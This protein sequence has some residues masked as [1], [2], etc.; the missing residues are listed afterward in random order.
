MGLVTQ[1]LR[2]LIGAA[3]PG[4]K[5]PSVR[6]LMS[7]YR[8]SPATVE[9]AFAQLAGE[10]L[11]DPKPGQGTFVRPPPVAVAEAEFGDADLSWQAVALGQGR[12][13]TDIMS[14]LLALPSPGTIA[15][16]MGYLPPDLQATG[17]LK[18][19]LRQAAGRPDLWDRLPLEGLEALR[20]WFAREVG[21][22]HVF[23]PHEVLVCPGGQAAIASTFRALVPPGRPLLVEAPTYVGAI[24]AARAAGVQL[25]PVPSDGNGVRPDLLADAFR[26]TGAK[27]FYGQPT[28]ANPSGVVLSP[29]RRVAVLDIARTARAFVIE[30]DWA[31]DLALGGPPPA[32]LATQ[33][34][35]G[36]VVYI[37]SL[38]K[39][40]APGLRV[41]AVM[42]R[43]A[44]L[45]RLRSSR[46]CD[47]FFVCGPLQA[48]AL[49]V[50][51]APGWKR[52]LQAARTSLRER[53]DALVAAL[54]TELG[55]RLAFHVPDGGMHLWVRLPDQV[56]DAAL[57]ADLA[58]RSVIV[59]PGWIWFPADPAGSYL[60]LTF[61]ASPATLRDGVKQ[62]RSALRPWL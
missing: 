33:D 32:P 54:R 16:S 6:M 50:V 1:A 3:A 49:A 40:A 22:G 30:D 14:A 45:A 41:A 4:A 34:R 2:D 18:E 47:D 8:V 24:A 27:A 13:D 38:A 39:S 29:D 59:S 17:L 37:R 26:Q 31:R 46:S 61:G 55:D 5:L 56:S 35:H 51:T 25:I 12:G 11:I 19:A 57:T 20:A 9:R 15:L 10:G 7:E 21:G 53:R 62:L 58:R 23:A 48:S 44:A 52:H 42:A 60:R 43:G 36:H 28:F